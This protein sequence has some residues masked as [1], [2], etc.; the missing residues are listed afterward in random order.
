MNLVNDG[1]NKKESADD[2]EKG[3][4]VE[5]RDDLEKMSKSSSDADDY[6]EVFVAQQ[7][8]LRCIPL[9]DDQKTKNSKIAE[10]HEEIEKLMHLVGK[11]D[12][13]YT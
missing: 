5:D 13:H 12:H 2:V 11:L 9:E 1:L 7:L 4:G 3:E 6:M 10:M 8:N